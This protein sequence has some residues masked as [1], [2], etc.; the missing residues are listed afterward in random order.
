MIIVKLNGGLG[1]QMFQYAAAKSLALIN[2]D[3]LKID[4]T[5]YNIPDNKNTSRT[6]DITDFMISFVEAKPNE[7]SS[8]KSPYGCFSN[9][10]R[11]IKQ[12]FLRKYY[13]DWHPEVMKK[14]GDIY[15]DGYF[16]SENYFSTKKELVLNDF[17]LKNH[18][19]EQI[20][21]N[22]LEILSREVSVSI[23]IRR[24][25]Y[26][27]DARARKFHLIC[28]VDYYQRAVNLVKNY[29]PNAHF[30][31]FSDDPQWVKENITF[32]ARASFVSFGRNNI[33]SLRASQE[34]ILMSKCCHHILSNSSFSWWG[35]Y[36]NRSPNKLVIAPDR[37]NNGSSLQRN[38][39]PDGW[40]RIPA[41]LND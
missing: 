21:L 39:L 20:N 31:I 36:L 8:I 17:V 32:S 15:M 14:T 3:D 35:A 4:T 40:L 6:L 22:A 26:V 2:N 7:I 25:D 12:R 33:G 9:L 28:N 27:S 5:V 34:L 11:Y 1:N 19:S 10:M 18:L 37:W 13:I 29:Y 16:Q 30:F 38:I 23:H 24:G 41:M